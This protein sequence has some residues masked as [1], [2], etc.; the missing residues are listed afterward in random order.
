M[1]ERRRSADEGKGLLFASHKAQNVF[2]PNLVPLLIFTFIYLLVAW[3]TFA[4]YGISPDEIDVINRGHLMQFHFDGTDQKLGFP[5]EWKMT[6]KAH[7][8]PLDAHSDA[9]LLYGNLS[10]FLAYHASLMGVSIEQW[11]FVNLVAV[12][13]VYWALWLVLFSVY[14]RPWMALVGPLLLWAIPRFSGCAPFDPKDVPFAVSSFTSLTALYFTYSGK[15]NIQRGWIWASGLLVG[16]AQ[17]QR[18][19]GYSLHG[20]SFLMLGMIW[21]GPRKKEWR[22]YAAVGG[23]IFLIAQAITALFWPYIGVPFLEKW[24]EVATATSRFEWYAP[25]IFKGQYLSNLNL[26]LSY[27]PYWFGVATP[28]F[29]LALGIGGFALSIW[30]PGVRG[31]FPVFGTFFFFQLLLYFFVKPVIYDGLRHYL[32]FYPILVLFA[33]ACLLEV[34]RLRSFLLKS[35]FAACVIFQ[36]TIVLRQDIVWHPYEYVYFNSILGGNRGAW[37]KMEFEVYGTAL[38]E[39]TRWVRQNGE[40]GEGGSMRV[41]AVGNPFQTEY[42]YGPGMVNTD[43]K[44]SDYFLCGTRLLCHELFPGQPAV[45]AIQREGIPLAVIFRGPMRGPDILKG[46]FP[47]MIGKPVSPLG[48]L[49]EK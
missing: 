14:H 33:G 13:P 9:H 16:T 46:E 10:G 31:L 22:H 5:M 47:E 7:S 35:I 36:A 49:S 1:R 24:R 17:C 8:G 40:R 32:F 20:V 48:V 27:L 3:W 4:D 30:R 11:H 6:V 37:R 18:F 23:L 2:P 45:H 39:A 25:M 19:L 26:P 44:R 29:W 15:P 21:L 12:L 28:L 38:G 43:M 41:S 42:Y 34:A